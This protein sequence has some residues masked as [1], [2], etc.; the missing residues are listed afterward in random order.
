MNKVLVTGAAGYVGSVLVRQLL[1]AGYEVVGV[2]LLCFGGESL[3]GV[4]NDPG[5]HLHVGDLRDP[6][7]QEEAL[8]GVDAVVHLAA[9]VGDPACARQPELAEALNWTVSKELFDRCTADG[10]R[11]ERFVFGSTCSNYGKMADEEWVDEDAPLRPISLYARLKVAMEEYILTR[12]PRDGLTATSL[13]FST[14]YGLSPR[15]RF[16][17]T[18]NEFTREIVLGRQLQIYGEQFWR[19]YCH[20]EDLAEACRMVLEA[21]PEVVAGRVFGVG[22]SSQNY[23]KATLAEMLR[24]IR[25]D[26]DIQFVHKEEDPRNYRVNFDRI[27]D[28]L[29]FRPRFTVQDGIN[30]IARAI[31]DGMITDPDNPNY[32]N[33]GP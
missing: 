5:F 27:R 2:D 18:V 4:I 12:D 25:P 11:I 32:R 17:L 16:D 19:P 6:A 9:I 33:I 28:E 13:R 1:R 14:I 23:Q 8:R 7:V 24:S 21:P 3:L 31:E 22:S 15:P 20:V 10:S 29:G 30:E 26:A